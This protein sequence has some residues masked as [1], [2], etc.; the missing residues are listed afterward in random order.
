MTVYRYNEILAKQNE[1]MQ[2]CAAGNILSQEHRKVGYPPHMTVMGTML[3]HQNSLTQTPIYML[4]F[5]S[6]CSNYDA[7]KSR[8][9]FY[10]I[11]VYCIIQL[12][13]INLFLQPFKKKIMG[14]FPSCHLCC[15]NERERNTI[16]LIVSTNT[17]SVTLTFSS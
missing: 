1:S 5:Y 14:S 8:W 13:T 12:L 2:F 3:K 15:I 11:Q 6:V 10:C 7:E 4:F 17:I 9:F 16:V